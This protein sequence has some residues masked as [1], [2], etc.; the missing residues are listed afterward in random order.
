M[1]PDFAAPKTG[2]LGANFPI[3]DMDEDSD[4]WPWPD[5]DW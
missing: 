3:Y 5:I 2:H 4:E 1:K